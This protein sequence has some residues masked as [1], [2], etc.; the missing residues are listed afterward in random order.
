MNEKLQSLEQFFDY[1]LQIKKLISFYPDINDNQGIV[2]Y[3]DTYDKILKEIKYMLMKMLQFTN[4]NTM[5]I[6]HVNKLFKQ[7]EK[8]LLKSITNQYKLIEFYQTCIAN[9]NPELIDEINREIKGYYVYC[10]PSGLILKSQTINELLHV[11]HSYVVNNE[12]FYEMMP[13]LE[14]KANELGNKII[15]RGNKVKIADKYL[16]ICPFHLIVL[17]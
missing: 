15:L 17:S 8:M 6:K 3:L 10:N 14:E 1:D 12:S 9:M 7:Y 11:L 2:Y 13:I 5:D 16:I 4:A